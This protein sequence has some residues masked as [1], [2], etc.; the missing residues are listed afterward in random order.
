MEDQVRQ[1][2]EQIRELQADNVRLRQGNVVPP[3]D[4]DQGEP[5]RPLPGPPSMRY[6]H[7]PRERKYPKF[8][9]SPGSECLPVEEWVEEIRQCLQVRHMSPSEQA[10]FV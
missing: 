7:V 3:V 6:V 8:S 10:Y 1:L 9:G 5:S 2:T 4:T